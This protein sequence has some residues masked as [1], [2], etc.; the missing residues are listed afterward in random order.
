MCEI[1]LRQ[2]CP[3]TRHRRDGQSTLSDEV[4]ELGLLRHIEGHPLSLFFH[5]GPIR[6]RQGLAEWVHPCAGPDPEL[7]SIRARIE[8]QCSAAGEIDFDR[9][10]ATYGSIWHG[11]KNSAN[12]VNLLAHTIQ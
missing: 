12:S 7:F 10:V 2:G 8:Q 9:T 11:V 6:S 4:G 1:E 5:K 3:R